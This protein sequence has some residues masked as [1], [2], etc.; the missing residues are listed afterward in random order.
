MQRD[1]K[2]G[3]MGEKSIQIWYPTSPPTSL[4][5]CPHATRHLLRFGLNVTGMKLCETIFFGHFF[6]MG[7]PSIRTTSFHQSGSMLYVGIYCLAGN[8]IRGNW[9][10]SPIH[11]IPQVWMHATKR[12]TLSSARAKLGAPKVSRYLTAEDGK[13]HLLLKNL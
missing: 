7:F 2:V 9:N 5:A 12:G 13:I 11:L 4:S 8:Q 3:E 1:R 6:P 10:L